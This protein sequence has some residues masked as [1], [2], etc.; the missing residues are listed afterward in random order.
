MALVYPIYLDTSMMA[1]FLASLEG[2]IVEETNVESRMSDSK[3]NT[4]AGSLRTK[5]GGLLS[6]LLDFEAGAEVAK[7]VS[8]L[9]ESHYKSTVRFPEASLFIRLRDTLF[10]EGL[11]KMLT[12][13]TGISDLTVGDLIEF[14]GLVLPHPAYQIRHIFGQL[15]PLLEPMSELNITQLENRF[16]ALREAKPNK[17]VKVGDKEITFA[18]QKA[19]TSMRDLIKTQQQT[20]R[21]EVEIRRI[22]GTVLSDLFSRPHIDTLLFKSEGFH[23]VSHV[24]PAF[25]RDERVEDIY[26]ASWCCLGKVIRILPESE[27]YD[28][29]QASPIG[30]FAKGLFPDLAAAFTNAKF[31]ITTTEPMVPGPIVI[32][33][34]LAVFV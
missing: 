5:I 1:A 3:E 34:P 23:V 16:I 2:G 19:I 7:K 25:A 17:P 30:Y 10:D 13:D 26:N 20:S 11:V 8:E 6:N 24:Y 33:A 22:M 4:Q 9:L 15:M 32:V 18:D 12:S 21:N 31:N 27:E 29:L 28:L 14:Q